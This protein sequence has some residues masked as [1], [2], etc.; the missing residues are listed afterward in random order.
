MI[1]KLLLC[2][3]SFIFLFLE[4]NSQTQKAKEIERLTLEWATAN[5][6]QR[7]D[8]L[9]PLYSSSLNFYGL[10]KDVK[11]CLGEKKDFFRRY[12]SYSI[13]ISN[14]DIDFYKSGIIRCNFVKNEVWENKA[15]SPQQ[16]Y[17]LFE[18]FSTGYK[19][20]AES[21]QRMDSQRGYVPQLGD[22]VQKSSN[23]TYMLIGAVGLFVVMGIVYLIRKNH[24]QKIKLQSTP[25]LYSQQLINGI[26]PDLPVFS[27]EELKKN[28]GLA[29]EHFVV[30]NFD[31]NYFKLVNWRGD[32]YVDGYYP[33]SNLDPDLDYIYQDNARKESFA[34][35]CKWRKD[36]VNNTVTIA[37]ERQLNNYRRY[38]NTKNY[39][40]FIILG[41]GG[42]GSQPE[43]LYIIPLNEVF[44]PI[45]TKERLSKY[46]RYKKGRFFL[47]IPTMKLQ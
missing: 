13:S 22:K 21:D 26:R 7:L 33:L 37:E 40:V 39:P 17:L 10:N 6:T 34:V 38:Q 19:I 47:E 20:I 32:K 11:T 28:Q 9:A 12:P 41:I 31:P 18:K 30:K 5:N 46:F 1:K 3:I 2:L 8:L 29:F 36:F 43:S 44:S 4:L 35:E 15:R 16:A 14:L 24:E 45:I 42:S 23:S 27:Q 25:M